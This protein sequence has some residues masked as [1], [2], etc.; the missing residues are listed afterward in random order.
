MTRKADFVY[1]LRP[2]YRGGFQKKRK[3]TACRMDFGRTQCLQ[4]PYR[5]TGA[6]RTLPVAARDPRSQKGS[7]GEVFNYASMLVMPSMSMSK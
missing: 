1:N 3:N 4:M 7:A 6:G 2:P 5:E